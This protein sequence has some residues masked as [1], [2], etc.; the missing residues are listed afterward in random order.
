MKP[1]PQ[2]RNISQAQCMARL[3]AERAGGDTTRYPLRE[4]HV[5][6]MPFADLCPLDKWLKGCWHP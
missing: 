1:K 2:T 6:T 4:R 5:K 3:R